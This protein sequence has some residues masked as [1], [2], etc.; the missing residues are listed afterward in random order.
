[1][2]A[3]G[4]GDWNFETLFKL[5]AKPG[6]VFDEDW[7]IS[8]GL[9]IQ[10]NEEIVGKRHWD[11]GGPGAGADDVLVTRYRGLFFGRD[12]VCPC[13]PFETFTQAAKAIQLFYWTDATV[14]IWVADEFKGDCP[15]RF[16]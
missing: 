6:E 16:R 4:Y 13:G 9:D 3:T 11:S 8:T 7:C 14:S 10:D 12:D 15:E 2:W 5:W 1:M